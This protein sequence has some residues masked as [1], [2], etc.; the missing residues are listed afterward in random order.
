[1]AENEFSSDQWMLESLAID[2]FFV[3][4]SEQDKSRIIKEAVD[5]GAHLAEKIRE[6]MGLPDGVE[7]IRKSLMTLGCGVRIDDETGPPGPMS[8]YE[9]DLL[10]ARFFTLRIRRRAE[11]AD[12][13]G[14]WSSGWNELYEQCLARELFHHVENTI[15]GKASHHIRFKERLLG[16]L[17]VS[18][19]VETSRQIAGL[20]FV[21]DYLGLTEIPLLM[22]DE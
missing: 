4:L 16:L 13:R 14:E 9:D 19:P 18:R 21:K 12:E 17:P 8:V 5:F 7:S 2:E 22:R 1:M 3:Q 6:K 10:A 15:S 20:I 11:E